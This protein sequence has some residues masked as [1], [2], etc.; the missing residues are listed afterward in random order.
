MKE[1]SSGNIINIIL[2][3]HASSGKTIFAEAMLYSAKKIHKMGS[4][5]A[6]TTTSDFRE[7]EKIQQVQKK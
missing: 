1:Y 4:I 2:S 6:G 7:L 3:G 5:D